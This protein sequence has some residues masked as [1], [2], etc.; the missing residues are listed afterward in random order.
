MFCDE[1]WLILQRQD[2]R[3]SLLGDFACCGLSGYIVIILLNFEGVQDYHVK[4][5]NSTRTNLESH[6]RQPKAQIDVA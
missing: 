5:C 2:E 6:A 3:R 4:S 1:P